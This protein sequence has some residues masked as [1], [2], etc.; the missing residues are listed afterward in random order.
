F[1]L[2]KRADSAASVKIYAPGIADEPGH[3]YSTE[4]YKGEGLANAVAEALLT[5][6]DNT[7]KEVFA[8]FNGENINAKEWGV[9]TI[10]NHKNFDN[11]FNIIHPADC[12]GDIGA[13]TG[14][15]LIALAS[16]GMQ[17]GYYKKPML[18]WAASEIQ[19]RAAVLMA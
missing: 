17:K 4:P 12:Y 13:A 8:S 6:S 9:A 1:L 18:I 11:D 10:R 3:R 19:Q 7:I 2:L 5:I 16:I 14:P 15:V